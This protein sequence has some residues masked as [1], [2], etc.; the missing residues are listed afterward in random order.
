MKALISDNPNHRRNHRSK[1]ASTE[2][3]KTKISFENR[4][5]DEVRPA[6]SNAPTL[7]VVTNTM[8]STAEKSRIIPPRCRVYV[9]R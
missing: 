5:R 7:N 1:K 2:G 3:P 8:R 4:G 6:A 9:D